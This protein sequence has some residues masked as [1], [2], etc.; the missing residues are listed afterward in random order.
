M[1]S[2]KWRF[3]GTWLCASFAVI[4]IASGSRAAEP[5]RRLPNQIYNRMVYVR[6]G[7]NTEVYVNMPDHFDLGSPS[8]SP[9][10]KWI[11]LDALTIGEYPR[12]EAW[13]VGVDGNGLR[14]LADGRLRDGR[15]TANGS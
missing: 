10:G 4:A 7:T 5:P 9:D 11:A 6:T 2:N 3:A 1:A 13:L 8:I 12:R 15:Q 14:K